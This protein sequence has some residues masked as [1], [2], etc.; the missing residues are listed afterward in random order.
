MRGG[1]DSLG[2]AGELVEIKPLVLSSSS[3]RCDAVVIEGGRSTQSVGVPE[4]MRLVA[5]ISGEIAGQAL[6]IRP[7]NVVRWRQR[8][9]S[10]GSVQVVHISAERIRGSAIIVGASHQS[11][12]AK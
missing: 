7:D 4:E 12:T 8:C 10:C 9:W 6:D 2:V 1:A 3:R 11:F 5:I